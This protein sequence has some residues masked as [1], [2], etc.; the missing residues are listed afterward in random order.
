VDNHLVDLWSKNS[1]E[2]NGDDDV[3]THG[4]F[5]REHSCGMEPFGITS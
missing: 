4:D 2:D 5:T 3:E 1:P